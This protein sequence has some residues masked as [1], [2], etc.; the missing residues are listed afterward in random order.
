MKPLHD[1]PKASTTRFAI[2]YPHYKDKLVGNLT[3]KFVSTANCLYFLCGWSNLLAAFFFAYDSG[4]CAT[5][6]DIVIKKGELPRTSLHCFRLFS[7][8]SL[9]LLGSTFLKMRPAI[10]KYAAM[11]KW[12]SEN[13]LQVSS[14]PFFA[15]QTAIKTVEFLVNNIALLNKQLQ[16]QITNKFRGL[17]HVKLD[18]QDTH[19]QIGY[20]ICLA[21]R[22]NKA[23]IHWS[24][25]Q[26][27]ERMTCNI[28]V[29]KLHVMAYRLAIEKQH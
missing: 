22:T 28:L 25:I 5:K 27:C 26:K 18:L 1:V 10:F 19:L 20:I 2:Y 21:N 6:L 11:S 24:S 16:Q 7:L 3:R 15:T 8:L 9:C 29:V 12:Q 23:N 14:N 4:T 13:L 17:R